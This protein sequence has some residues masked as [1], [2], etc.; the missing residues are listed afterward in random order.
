MN[1]TCPCQLIAIR[2]G[3]GANPGKYDVFLYAPSEPKLGP[4][5]CPFSAQCVVDDFGDLVAVPR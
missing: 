4:W 3:G 1:T 2:W 5:F